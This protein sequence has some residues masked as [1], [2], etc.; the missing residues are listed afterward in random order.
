MPG[1]DQVGELPLE[2]MVQQAS[3]QAVVLAREQVD[4]ARR[5]L[6]ARARQAGSGAAMGSR[7]SFSVHSLPE[8]ALPL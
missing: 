2:E 5:E 4:V 7:V 3:Q 6:A 8:P 1:V